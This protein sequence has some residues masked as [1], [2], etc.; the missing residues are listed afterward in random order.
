MTLAPEHTVVGLVGE[1]KEVSTPFVRDMLRKVTVLY[2]DM[3][4]LRFGQATSIP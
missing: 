3:Q 2:G 1:P 4:K